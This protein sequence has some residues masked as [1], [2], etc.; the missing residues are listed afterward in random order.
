MNTVL[1][2]SSLDFVV[3]AYLKE[4][5][6]NNPDT[7]AVKY[8]KASCPKLMAFVNFMDSKFENDGMSKE[9]AKQINSDGGV[10]SNP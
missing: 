9:M 10:S 4:E 3:Y 1:N 8:L 7:P 6:I 2:F 5:I